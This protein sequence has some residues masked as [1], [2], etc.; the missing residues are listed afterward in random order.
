MLTE[1]AES[2]G[3]P[4]RVDGDVDRRQSRCRARGQERCGGPPGTW[5]PRAASGSCCENRGAV[6]EAGG[7]PVARNRWG[8]RPHRCFHA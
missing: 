7:K 8:M 2:A 1:G 3:R 5:I 6:S 4:C